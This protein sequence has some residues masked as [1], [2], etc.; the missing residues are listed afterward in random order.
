[1]VGDVKQEAGVMQRPSHQLGMQEA[2]K[3]KQRDSPPAFPKGTSL[4]TS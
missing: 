4:L 2:R 1:M 3:A